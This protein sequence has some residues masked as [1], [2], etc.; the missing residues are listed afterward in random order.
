[1]NKDKQVDGR[2][3]RCGSFFGVE[4]RS[5]RSEVRS[6]RLEVGG[7]KVNGILKFDV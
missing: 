6:Q 7:E 5:Q 1:M 2:G 3:K 4:V